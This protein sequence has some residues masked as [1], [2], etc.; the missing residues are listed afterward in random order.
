[1]PLYESLV[2]PL[3]FGLPPET[4]HNLALWAAS[5]G[6][7][8]VSLA[9]RDL[10]KTL[11]AV[12]FPNPIGLAAG[13]DKDA[14]ALDHWK[15]FGFGF[16]EVG[17]VTRHAQPGNP[18]PR[19][20]RLREERAIINRMG[21]NNSGADAMARRLERA[22]PGI[23]VGVNI[24]KS[25]VTPL[26]NAH[27][28]YAY[29]YRLLKGFADYVVVNVSSPNTPGLRDLQDK[30]SLTKILSALK[31]IDACK[32]LFV[33]I[34]PD[35]SLG[36]IEDVVG[37]A[38]TLGLTGIVATNTTIARDMLPHDPNIQGGLSGAPL[39]AMADETLRFLNGICGDELVL[40]GCGGVMSPTDARRK[41][42]LGAE[43]VQVYTGWVYGGPGFVGKIVEA[44]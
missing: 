43:L 8:R 34:A 28:D 37:V 12:R 30:E 24:G 19:L 23:P 38:T 29:S 13:F 15:N 4:A 26:E 32:P 25:K 42:S 5:K 21:F 14:V 31:E 33:K 39:T 2:K 20:F 35:L 9:S 44:L 6:L 41:F 10:S 16:V 3:L 7:G 17:T 27:E 18:K 40:I 11:F 22:N 1:M 36:S